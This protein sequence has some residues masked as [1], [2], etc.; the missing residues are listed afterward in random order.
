MSIWL[1]N[2]FEFSSLFKEDTTP[3]QGLGAMQ[4]GAR[5]LKFLCCRETIVFIVIMAKY[6]HFNTLKT[7][8]AV[9]G[10]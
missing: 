6:Q 10:S 8:P 7:Q 5:S 2:N 4:P 9:T 3:T 1:Y